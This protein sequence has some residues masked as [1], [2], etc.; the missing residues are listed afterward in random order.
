MEYHWPTAANSALATIT[1]L[2]FPTAPEESQAQIDALYERFADQ[3]REALEADVFDRSQAYGKAVAMAIF[4]W[5]KTDGG[6]EGYMRSFPADYVAPVAAGLWTP[7]PRTE[8]DPQPALL[9]YWG[10]NRTFMPESSEECMPSAP[11]AYSE[12]ADSVFYAEAM[13]V[14]ETGKSLTQEQTEIAMFWSDDPGKT[15]TPPGHTI[16]ILTQILEQEEASLAF[17]AEAYAK[18]GIAVADSFIGCW[19]AKYEYNLVRPVTYIQQTIET[20]WMPIL[21]TPPF[22]EYPSGHSVQ[23]GAAGIVLAGLFG[24]AYTFTDHT[25]EGIGLAARSFDSFIAM[26]DEAAL[27]RLYGGIH[28][29]SAIELGLDQGR[30]IGTRVESLVF[31]VR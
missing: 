9:P 18:V 23:I 14:Y 1:Q 22:P 20:T 13:E 4:E 26:A 19:K 5:S 2:L 11:P 27:S 12:E 30:C 21:N 28:F 24:D 10:D 7:T 29:R 8:G 25:H 17:A 6:H 31:E 15:A 16:S 3:Y